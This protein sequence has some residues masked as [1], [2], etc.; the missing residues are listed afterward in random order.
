MKKFLLISLFLWPL[1]GFSQFPL[2]R[3]KT[4]FEN[5][6]K[7]PQSHYGIQ[8]ICVLDAQTGKVLYAK[9][10]NIGLAT[11]ST[12]KTITSATALSL[13]G[14]DYRYQTQLT[15]TGTI[16]AQGVLHG[17]LIIEGGGDPSLGSWRFAS[18]KE[19]IILQ[20]MVAAIKQ[21][22]IRKIKGRIIGDDTLFGTQSLPSGWI[23]QDIGNYYGAGSGALNWR[24]NQFDVKLKP[25]A[26]VG[27]PV[28]VLGTH[29]KMPYLSISNELT[30]GLAGS[31]DNA[32]GYLGPFAQ[33]AYLRGTWGIGINKAAISLS[34]PEPAYDIAFRLKDSL[35]SL[36]FGEAMMVETAR[37]LAIANITLPQ[38]RKIITTIESP[39]MSELVYWFNQKSI[40][41]YGEQMVKTIAY[42]SGK[43]ATTENG[44]KAIIDF[45]AAKGIDS[46][47]LKM[48]DGSGL[49]PAN[50][51][52]TLAMASILFQVQKESWFPIFYESLPLYNGMKIKSGNINSV[53][54]YAGYH[55]AKNGQKY[56][57]VINTNNYNGS[58][59]SQ[60]LFQVLNILK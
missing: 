59:I 28:Q 58:G 47:A 50:R 43:K 11:A 39:K 55:T 3:L 4:A 40:N 49:S 27:S 36:A 5:F 60:K 14:K 9:N 8:S 31:G 30:T 52:T 6:E 32:Y 7:D 13:L 19:E 17:D 18:T 20:K 42:E 37:R 45:W 29:P 38:S 57:V 48:I 54:A 56:V 25:G 34:S 12:L 53:T 41:L 35:E 44:V 10:E 22:G 1:L 16:D 46:K 33:T 21:V 26:Q 23:W 2:D 15:Y 51:V 24:E